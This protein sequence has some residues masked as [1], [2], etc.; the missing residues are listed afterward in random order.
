MLIAVASPSASSLDSRIKEVEEMGEQVPDSHAKA[1][2]IGVLDSDT[3][4]HTAL[5]QG[6]ASYD[7]LRREVLKF[8]NYASSGPEPVQIG[9]FGLT[10]GV[11][12]KIGNGPYQFAGIVP[13]WIIL[14]MTPKQ[15]SRTSRSRTSL[16]RMVTG[17]HRNIGRNLLVKSSSEQTFAPRKTSSFF[18]PA[19]C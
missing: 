17:V 13:S 18:F 1:S 10:L 12:F 2:V 9:S 7:S 15:P 3:R 5:M 16:S 19:C 6:S 4:K 11:Y 8:V 14:V